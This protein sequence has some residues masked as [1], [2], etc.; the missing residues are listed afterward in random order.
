MPRCL[1]QHGFT[2]LVIPPEQ[3]TPDGRFPTCPSPNPE[4]REALEVGLR[5]ARET[6]SELLLAT[7]PDCDRVGVAVRE[8]EDYTLLNGNETGVLLFDF[9]CRMR[10]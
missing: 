1:R 5:T 7:D 8:G 9:V 6:G 2:R 3:G 4:I 10:R